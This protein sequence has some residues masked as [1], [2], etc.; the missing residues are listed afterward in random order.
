MVDT[1]QV[2]FSLDGVHTLMLLLPFLGAAVISDLSSR[3][4]PNVLVALMFAAGI[5]A[6]VTAASTV[7]DGLRAGLGGAGVGLLMLLPFYVLGGMGAGDVKLLAATGAFLGLPGALL[8]GL[9]TLGA[10]AVLGLSVVVCHLLRTSSMAR[11]LVEAAPTDGAPTQ[12]PYSLAISIGAL[13]AV[14][15]W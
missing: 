10:G 6:Q 12:L 14:I 15:S 9:F 2:G 4:V 7:G 1:A 3:R 11:C 13:G 8:A 5:A